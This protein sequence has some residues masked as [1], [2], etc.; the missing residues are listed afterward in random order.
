MNDTFA[1]VTDKVTGAGR[2]ATVGVFIN[3]LARIL[4]VPLSR[5][6]SNNVNVNFKQHKW[7]TCQN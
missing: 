2:G 6:I 4:H 1:T 5:F 7:A 3:P